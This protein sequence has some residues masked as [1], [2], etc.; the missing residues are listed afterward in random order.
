MAMQR[1]ASSRPATTS[2]QSGAT[3]RRTAG[4]PRGRISARNCSALGASHSG[5]RD[6]ASVRDEF[7]SVPLTA[8]RIDALRPESLDVR[9]EAFLELLL[10]PRTFGAPGDLGESEQARKG[11]ELEV[12]FRR[13]ELRPDAGLDSEDLARLLRR[14]AVG[15]RFPGEHLRDGLRPALVSFPWCARFAF[16]LVMV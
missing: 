13:D 8:P 7:I 3:A 2:A 6:K 14:E 10:V 5:I 12:A 4:R 16:A 11:H 1:C 15:D 9:R